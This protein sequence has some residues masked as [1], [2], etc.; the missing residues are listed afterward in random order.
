[1]HSKLVE[2]SLSRSGCLIF[3]HV[4]VLDSPQVLSSRQNVVNKYWTCSCALNFMP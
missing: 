1:M 4:T 2:W 3:Q